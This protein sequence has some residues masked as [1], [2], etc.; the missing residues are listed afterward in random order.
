MDES[1]RRW[2]DDSQDDFDAEGVKG[3]P[4]VSVRR[5][6]DTDL[7][8]LSTEVGTIAGQAVALVRQ[9]RQTLGQRERWKDGLGDLRAYAKDRVQELRRTAETHAEE[10]RRA[11]LEKTA[12]LRQQARSRYEQALRRAEQ[13]GRDYPLQTV[14]V[15]GA[16]GFLLGVVLRRRAH[17]AR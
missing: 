11:A 14:V 4:R 17:R 7:E 9:V 2:S 15:A 5:I 16:A 1:W 3:K 8:R 10:W 13:A 12:E 6:R